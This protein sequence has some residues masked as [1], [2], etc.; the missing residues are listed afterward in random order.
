MKKRIGTFFLCLIVIVTLLPVTANADTGPKPSVRITFENMG[1]EICYG[2]LLSK[3]DSTGP[4]SAWDGKEEHICN[5]NLDLD[6]WEAFVNYEDPDGYYFLQE[7]WLCSETKQLN[8]TYYPPSPFK[9]LLYYPETDTF[10]VSEIYERYAFDSYFSVNMD[11]IEI[12]S[13]DAQA[14]V[15]TADKNYDYTWELISLVSRIVITI[16]L[17]ICIALIFGFRQKRLLA[18]ITGINIVTQVILNVMLNIINYNQ[19]SMAFVLSYIALE[20]IVFAIEAVLYS[21][22][23]SRVSQTKIPKWKSTFYALTA[24]AGSFAAGFFIAKLIPGIF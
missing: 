12:H 11:G 7:G 5:Y 4:C 14:A 22:L 16:L 15:L 3:T 6:I 10:V 9:I 19:G 1:D 17:E 20:L 8:W 13:A 21:L 18:L 24:N 23:F 2:T